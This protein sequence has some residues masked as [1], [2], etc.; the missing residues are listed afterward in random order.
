MKRDEVKWQIVAKLN[1]KLSIHKVILVL[2]R[3]LCEIAFCQF[4]KIWQV[5]RHFSYGF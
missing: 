2:S 5:V 4:S 1:D 3:I